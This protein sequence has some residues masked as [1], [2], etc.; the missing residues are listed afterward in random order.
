MYKIRQLIYKIRS[1]IVGL[2][3]E[4][5]TPHSMSHDVNLLLYNVTFH[6]VKKLQVTLRRNDLSNILRVCPNVQHLVVSVVGNTTP[7]V[8]GLM[9]ASVNK[10]QLDFDKCGDTSNKDISNMLRA[11][12]N[13]LHLV[14]TGG[15]IV[16]EDGLMMASIK[17]LKL[18]LNIKFGD[19]S[20]KDISNILRAC[21]N[22]LYLVVD[23]D[24]GNIVIEDGLM[25]ASV[26]WMGLKWIGQS[27][28]ILLRTAPNLE[29]LTII[30]GFT[31][32]D[33][34]FS[35]SKLTKLSLKNV[36]TTPRAK[37]ILKTKLPEALK[38]KDCKHEDF[39]VK[40]IN[41]IIFSLCKLCCITL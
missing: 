39:S 22:L 21:P 30:G 14:V 6:N 2:T 26:K 24:G 8:D 15:N 23:G 40:V 37:K 33:Q 13:L 19:F 11:C 38:W 5:K 7:I 12:P 27:G 36:E 4:Q 35:L 32:P 9:L 18:D 10:L 16:I 41:L 29:Q 1:R 28:G 3:L 25:M 34:D 20:I 31:C 17:K